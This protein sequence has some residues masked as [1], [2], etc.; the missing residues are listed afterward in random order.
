MKP[1]FMAE[2]PWVWSMWE[3]ESR[4]FRP[5]NDTS[6]TAPTGTKQIRTYR[7]RLPV[8]AGIFGMI[9]IVILRQKEAREKKPQIIAELKDCPELS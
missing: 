4:L 5:L 2:S 1:Q 8:Q 3:R 9:G 6:R 7:S